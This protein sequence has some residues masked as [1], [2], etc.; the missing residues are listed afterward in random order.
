MS[1]RTKFLS[2]AQNYLHRDMTHELLDV[3]IV[4]C[5]YSTHVYM[6]CFN[7]LYKLVQLS[8]F[9]RR[10]NMVH[11]TTRFQSGQVT[12]KIIVFSPVSMRFLPRQ[13]RT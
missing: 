6:L 8:L 10:L 12:H 5:I 7:V 11:P 3:L 4:R 9:L 13:V 1:Y 2:F